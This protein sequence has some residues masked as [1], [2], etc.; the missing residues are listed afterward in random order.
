MND[1]SL[2]IAKRFVDVAALATYIGVPT[3]WIYDR[4]SVKHPEQIPHFKFGKYVR[5]DIDS[6]EFKAWLKQN[7]KN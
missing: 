7:F 1:Q 5:F 4:T 2:P 6:E 3:S